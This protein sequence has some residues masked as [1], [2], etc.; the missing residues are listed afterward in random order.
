MM[1]GSIAFILLVN[2]KHATPSPMSQSAAEPFFSSGLPD[3]FMSS[4]SSTPSGRTSAWYVPS[5]VKN[6]RRPFSTR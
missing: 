4:S 6:S 2:S 5:R 3:S 1:S